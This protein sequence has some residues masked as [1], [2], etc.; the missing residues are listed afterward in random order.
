MATVGHSNKRLILSASLGTAKRFACRSWVLKPALE[1]LHLARRASN[2]TCC[3]LQSPTTSP[4]VTLSTIGRLAD[5]AS[6]HRWS[7]GSRTTLLTEISMPQMHFPK[8]SP[9]EGEEGSFLQQGSPLSSCKSAD[10]K[11]TSNLLFDSMGEKA[12]HD[13]GS[14]QS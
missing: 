4:Q 10:S 12:G 3:N 5:P 13:N 9:C 2:S 1:A 14:H 11:G 8:S 7:C 6:I